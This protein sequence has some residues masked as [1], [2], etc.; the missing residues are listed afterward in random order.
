[1]RDVPFTPSKR[2]TGGRRRPNS[3]QRRKEAEIK[4]LDE[5]GV[6][7]IGVLTDQ[8]FLA[9]GA[10]LYAGEGSKT[11]GSVNFANCDPVMVRFFCD[12][13]RYFFVVD[14]SRLRVRIYLHEGLDLEAANN[15]WSEVTGVPVSQFRSPY[16]AIPDPSIRKTKHEFGCV[17]V[18]YSCTM[19][20]RAIMGLV[21]ALLTSDFRSGVAQ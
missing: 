21:R 2:R 15:H 16:R 11:P 18:R 3:L 17:Y 4:R 13:L 19:T 5:E 6:A 8:A 7:R 20:H 12:W 14:E 10:A 9:A 1:M